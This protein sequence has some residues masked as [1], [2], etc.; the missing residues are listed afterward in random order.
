MELRITPQT[1]LA[2]AL[3]QT[4]LQTARL[5]KLQIQAATGKKILLPSD[6]PARLGSLVR[7]QGQ[8]QR[9]DTYL[10]NLR[11]AR[12]SLDL[13]VSYLRQGSDILQQGRNLALE[14]AQ[15]T[16]DPQA[17][18][19]I[20]QQVDRLLERLLEAA[21]SQHNGRFL[22]SGTASDQRPFQVTGIDNQG[23]PSGVAY[24]GAATRDGVPV[25]S[26]QVI[27]TL[28]AGS[29][30]FQVRQR[31]A[32]VYAGGT[33][34]APGTGTDSATGTGTLQVR[35]TLTTFAPGS[36]VLAGTDSATGDTILGPS[37][38]HVLTIHDTSGTGAAG[39]ISLNGGPPTAFTNG[40]TN[41]VVTGPLGEKVHL[42]TTAIT[43]GFNGPIALTATG[44]LSLDG[45][46]TQVPIDFSANQQVVHGVTGVVTNVN[47]ANIRAAGS[48]HLEYSGTP[49]AFQ[50]LIALRDDLRNV[51]GLSGPEQLHAISGRV[52]DLDRARNGVL[53]AVGEQSADLKTL[54][55]LDL[56]LQD[57]QLTTRKFISE[58]EDVDLGQLI[59]EL[60][61]QQ[62]LLE[63]TLGATARVMS[64]SLLDFL[65]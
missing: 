60:Q 20:A 14:A 25:N 3:A 12:S 45:G 39:T 5:G 29:G 2:R 34:A 40:E 9:L 59:L 50:T 57:L 27:P 42:D 31:A 24:V 33:G 44:T 36:G 48:A 53:A 55:D 37:G 46:A 11:E 52:A 10:S 18:E 4:S 51:R 15:S 16:N 1:T 43:P 23:R 21:N 47:S 54:E 58:L 63:L 61:G 41:L 49:D 65:R 35:H 56:H 30:I 17:H 6:D 8:D 7:N 22:F 62:N 26:Q 38:S 13:S 19:A 28:Y 64:I 32:T